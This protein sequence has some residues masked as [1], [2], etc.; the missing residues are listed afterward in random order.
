MTDRN[1]TL[2]LIAAV[3]V[4]ALVG[5]AFLQRTPAQAT[6]TNTDSSLD[7]NTTTPAPTSNATTTTPTEQKT[8]ISELGPRPQVDEIRHPDDPGETYALIN[9]TNQKFIYKDTNTTSIIPYVRNMSDSE[10]ANSDGQYPRYTS[11]NRSELTSLAIYQNNPDIAI[12]NS[13]AVES[14]FMRILNERRA[15]NGK[16]PYIQSDYLASVAR[17]HDHDMWKHNYQGHEDSDG[18]KPYQRITREAPV[19]CYNTQEIVWNSPILQSQTQHSNKSTETSLAVLSYN[20]FKGSER[21]YKAMM[22]SYEDFQYAGTGVY[23]ADEK[24][25]ITTNFCSRMEPAE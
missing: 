18:Q 21:H 8:P 11:S 3:V 2:L 22:F 23:F 17:S 6:N 12:I 24:W 1:R 14:E 4:I 20:V 19:D 9:T 7:T 13:T 25:Y 10:R 15:A 5:G 16:K